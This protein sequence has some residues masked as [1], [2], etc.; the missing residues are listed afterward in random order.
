MILLYHKDGINMKKTALIICLVLCTVFC[1]AYC[2]STVYY[3]TA[4][5]ASPQ[6]LYKQNNNIDMFIYKNAAYVNASDVD[7]VT[8]L[9]FEKKDLLFNINKTDVTKDF[10]NYDATILDIDTP[11]YSTDNNQI[12]IAETDRKAIPYLIFVEG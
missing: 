8:E 1:I 3:S 4:E 9:N 10:Q 5:N 7:W 11:V 2:K 12:L 6:Y